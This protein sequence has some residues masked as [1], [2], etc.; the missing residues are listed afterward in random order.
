MRLDELL[1]IIENVSPDLQVL[2]KLPFYYRQLFLGKQNIDRAFWTGRGVIL[3]ESRK[4]I[5]RFRQGLARQDSLSTGGLLILGEQN[6]GKTYLSQYIAGKHF[7]KR[8]IY[9]INPPEGG[10]IDIQVFAKVLQGVINDHEETEPGAKPRTLKDV[11]KDSV[12]IFNDIELWWE[13][14]RDGLVVIEQMLKVINQYGG[15][16]FFIFNG[17]IH[18]FRYINRLINFSDSFQKMLECEPFSAEELKDIMLFRH[19]STGIKYRLRNKRED[20]ISGW[21]QARL[22]SKHFNYSKGN[23]G[24]ALNAW[25]SNIHSVNLSDKGAEL[26]VSKGTGLVQ[27]REPKIPNLDRLR[28]MNPDWLLFIIQFILHKK[29]TVQK[30]QRVSH[31]PAETVVSQLNLLLRAGVIVVCSS[32]RKQVQNTEDE[33]EQPEEVVYELNQFLRPHLV[34]DLVERGVL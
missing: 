17:N 14:S 13:R 30:L 2:D 4:A 34:N 24:V 5:E 20:D 11:E 21:R 26:S 28:H 7:N 12:F 27:I 25:I 10:S 3:L 8:K 31:L 32:V 33:S 18:S 29:M 16:L 22:F 6:S 15:K 23:V 1:T 9:Q 19:K